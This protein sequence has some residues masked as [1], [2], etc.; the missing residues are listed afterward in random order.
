MLTSNTLQEPGDNVKPPY[1]IGHVATQLHADH[2]L[3][4]SRLQKTLDRVTSTV[5]RPSVVTS[6]AVAIIFW[7]VA[8]SA[9][10]LLGLTPIDGTP[11]AMAQG[12]CCLVAFV[13]AM[14]IL[15]TQRRE[16]QLATQRAQLMLELAVVSDQKLSKVIELL[17]E[18]RRDNPAI[19]DRIDA[20]AA[21]MS[22][23]SDTHA[24]LEAIK[25][26]REETR[27]ELVQPS[28]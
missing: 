7:V 24:V 18:V 9:A 2:R 19:A 10:P 17:E 8:N 22:M 11:F 12:F 27:A 28:M 23:P 21:S 4:T 6:L 14:L 3:E 16:D 20:A 15:T 25:D 13:F 26:L 1:G 5:G